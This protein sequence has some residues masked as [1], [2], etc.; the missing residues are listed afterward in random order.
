MV[1]RSPQLGPFVDTSILILIV[2]RSRGKIGVDVQQ[3][4]VDASICSLRTK[5]TNSELWLGAG[6]HSGENVLCRKVL[7]VRFLNLF[8]CVDGRCAFFYCIAL[9]N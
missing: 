4:L 5:F 6:E 8:P 9:E 1:L 7:W 2:S 3:V